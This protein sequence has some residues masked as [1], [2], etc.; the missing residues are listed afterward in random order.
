MQLLRILRLDDS[1]QQVYRP[2]AAA[3]ELALPGAFMFTFAE[4]DPGGL[5]GAELHAF[6][7]GFLGID[8]FGWGTLVTVGEV[9]ADERTHVLERLSTLFEQRFGAPDAAA[10]RDQAEQEL[11]FAER[12]CQQPLNTILS[13]ERSLDAEGSVREQFR[14]HRQEARWEN[15]HPIFSIIRDEGELTP[16]GE[17]RS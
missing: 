5:D 3:G 8:S 13:L 15:E 12:L 14:V 11:A 10:A 17:P 6:R 1:D 9:T 7:R 4:R 16:P 2:A